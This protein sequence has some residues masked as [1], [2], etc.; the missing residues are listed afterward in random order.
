M[1]VEL[2]GTDLLKLA[3]GEPVDIDGLI[4]RPTDGEKS[5]AHHPT[6]ASAAKYRADAL[7]RRTNEEIRASRSNA[8][9]KLTGKTGKAAKT[10][11]RW[12]HAIYPGHCY[13]EGCRTA[14]LKGD[15]IVYDYDN[16]RALCEG[17]G[18]REF[19]TLPKP[20]EVKT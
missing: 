8:R 7:G 19:P 3:N 20:E 16:R 11:Q 2:C 9:A 5:F 14:I 10:G 12:M 15:L 17:H 18:A 6:N 1:I 13:M 4:V